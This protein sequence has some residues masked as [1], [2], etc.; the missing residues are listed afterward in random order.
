[1]CDKPDFLFIMGTENLQRS[2]LLSL[3]FGG[4]SFDSKE[5]VN[6]DC[7]IFVLFTVTMVLVMS[8]C[9]VREL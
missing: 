1:M 6:V 3:T 8:R 4:L 5:G 9:Q 7:L 2:V